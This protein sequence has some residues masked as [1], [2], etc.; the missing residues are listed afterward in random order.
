ML[1]G[2]IL[3]EVTGAEWIDPA[4][5]LAVAGAIVVAGL[6][7]VTRSSRVLVD[8]ALPEEEREAIARRGASPSDPRGVAGF[9]ELRTRR[10]GA[11]RY[12]DLHVQFRAGTT[13]EDAHATAHELQDAIAARL[14][15]ADVLIHLEP[16]DRCAREPRSRPGDARPDEGSAQVDRRRRGD[17]GDAR[18]HSRST[19]RSR[20]GRW[21]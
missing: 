15:N 13:L 19:P 20:A 12:V 4:V 14:R 10:G 5:A 6:R 21:R 16:E 18:R 11:H 9:H 17:R 7:L 1:A 2:L 8:E 3:V